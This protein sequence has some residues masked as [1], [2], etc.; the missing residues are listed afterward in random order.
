MLAVSLANVVRSQLT[1]EDSIRER[2]RYLEKKQ[3]KQLRS[4]RQN[5]DR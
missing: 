2:V 1:K 4:R 5:P 3:A